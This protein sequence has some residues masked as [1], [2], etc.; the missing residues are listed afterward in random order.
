MSHHRIHLMQVFGP[1]GDLFDRDAERCGQFGPRF[2]SI[3]HEFVQ[4]R[5]EQT[6][7][8]R[9]PPIALSV[10]LMSLFT[11]TKSSS[12]AFT[13]SSRVCDRIILRSAKS[14]FSLFLP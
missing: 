11:K 1:L 13:R 14:G 5:V 2:G 3:R 6:E 9:Q 10:F 12:S 4:R 7:G 8:D